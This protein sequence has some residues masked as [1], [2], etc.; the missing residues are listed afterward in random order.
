MKLIKEYLSKK[1]NWYDIN[2]H[3]IVLVVGLH[4]V[5][6]F[7]LTLPYINLFAGL[8]SF[9]PYLVDWIAILVLFRPRKEMILKIG[10]LLFGLS[11]ICTLTKVDFAVEILGQIT[12]FMIGT[13]VVLSLKEIRNQ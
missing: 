7:L 9:S 6:S 2:A 8:F 13:Y 3:K 11:Y 1:Y 5:S 12:F 10:L 4:L